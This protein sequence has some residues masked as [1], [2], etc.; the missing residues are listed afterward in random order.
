[1]EHR[2][3]LDHRSACLPKCP[4]NMVKELSFS[5]T[6]IVIV[7]LLLINLILI[8]VLLVAQNALII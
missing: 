7:I 6:S 4:Y 2:L 5:L 8:I 1:M 3:D